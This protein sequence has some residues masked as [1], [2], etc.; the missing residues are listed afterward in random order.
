LQIMRVTDCRGF[1]M[2]A[3][4][5]L[6]AVRLKVKQSQKKPSFTGLFFATR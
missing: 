4:Q 2:W 6:I 5:C 1:A 3:Q